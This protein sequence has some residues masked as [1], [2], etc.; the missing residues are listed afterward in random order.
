MCAKFSAA[1]IFV[2][3]DD[4]EIVHFDHADAVADR[5]MDLAKANQQK[6][7]SG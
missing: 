3:L 7:V 4:N 5:L 6:L 2:F 1:K